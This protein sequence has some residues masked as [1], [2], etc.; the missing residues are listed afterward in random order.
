MNRNTAASITSKT[1]LL[2]GSFN[3]LHIGHLRLCVEI[4]ERT[5]LD[6]V[7]LVPA[8]VPPH[9]DISDILPFDMRCSMLGSAV[10]NTPGISVNTLEK[11]RSGPSY[12]FDTLKTLIS[13]H[14]RNRFYFIMGDND[15]L[16]LPKWYRGR[17]I[18]L[19]C[20][21]IIAG[22][23]GESLRE[24]DDFITGFWNVRK[25]DDGLWMVGGGKSIRHIS[26][27][28]L[29]V[30]SSMIRSRWLAGKNIRWLVPDPVKDYL[31]LYREEIQ[32]VWG[33]RK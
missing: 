27:P 2:G 25:A 30:S 23:E 29:D 28:R 26:M 14:P 17:D 11:E 6:T 5:D 7:Q 21:L 16:T 13:D 4:M 15:L 22:R 9:K 20:D 1:G 31:D 33:S 10:E 18:A 19:L 8:Y 12:T 24:L 32:R 3:P